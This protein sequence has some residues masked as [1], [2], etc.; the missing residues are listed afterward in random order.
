MEMFSNK[1]QAVIWQIQ[2][3]E[4]KGKWEF[5]GSSVKHFGKKATDHPGIYTNQKRRG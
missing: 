2:I 3:L 1:E 5:L 4:L